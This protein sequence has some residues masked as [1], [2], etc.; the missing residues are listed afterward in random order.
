MAKSRMKVCLIVFTPAIVIGLLLYLAVRPDKPVRR[1]LHPEE[2]RPMLKRMTGRELVGKAE[3]LRAIFYRYG[4]VEDLFV[5]F[6]TDQE[7]CSD[8]LQAFGGQNVRMEEFPDVENGPFGWTMAGFRIGYA[9]ELSRD[10]FDQDLIDRIRDDALEYY[11]LGHYP[12][13]AI[14]GYYLEC[15]TGSES[16]EIFYNVLIFKDEGVVYVFGERCPLGAYVR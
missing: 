16:H 12:K 5:A 1:E 2:I 7:G 13:D 11:A 15:S 4:P 9:R 8:V 6:Q 14:T 10:P 3:G